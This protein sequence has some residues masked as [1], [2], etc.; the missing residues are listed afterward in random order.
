MVLDSSVRPIMSMRFRAGVLNK[1]HMAELFKYGV[2]KNAELDMDESASAS[3][4]HLGRTA[5]VMKGTTKLSDGEAVKPALTGRHSVSQLDL[6]TPQTLLPNTPYLIELQ[7]S[8]DFRD[9][10]ELHARATGKS[11]IGRLGVLTHL[12]VNGKSRYDRVDQ[13]Y[14]GNLYIQV[15]S[16]TFPLIVKEGISLNQLRVFWGKPDISEISGGRE[17]F[18]EDPL[19]LDRETPASEQIEKGYLRLDLAPTDC[20]GQS[21]SAFKARPPQSLEDAA[22]DPAAGIGAYDPD[23]YWERVLDAE[24]VVAEPD[25]LYILRSLERLRLPRDVAVTCIAMTENLGDVR[26]HYAGFAHPTFGSK[27]ADRKIGTPLIFE[28]R[29]FTK[30]ILRSEEIFADIKFYRMSEPVPEAAA[31]AANTYEEQELKLSKI[32]RA[33]P[34]AN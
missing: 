6:L 5:F 12:I 2:V 19:L 3:D 10:P 27:R 26:I 21:V 8:L 1:A 16:L 7:E 4:L 23:K 33:W 29:C 14:E 24:H 11:S 9:H 22:L 30:Q 34:A 28:V 18:V 17:A 15:T 31:P 32:F 20:G 25:R 13:C